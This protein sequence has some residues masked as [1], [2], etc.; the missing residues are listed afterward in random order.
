MFL[1]L[2]DYI[3][4]YYLLG[5]PDEVSTHAETGPLSGGDANRRGEQVKKTEGG[6]CDES[7]KHDFIHVLLLGREAECDCGYYETL[8]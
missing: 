7:N 6:S 4:M 3:V 8:E 1:H 2:L 5:K